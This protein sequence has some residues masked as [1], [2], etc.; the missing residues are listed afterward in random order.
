LCLRGCGISYANVGCAG[1]SRPVAPGRFDSIHSRSSCPSGAETTRPRPSAAS[2]F[3]SRGRWRWALRGLPGRR[4]WRE[5]KPDGRGERRGRLG[6]AALPTT[7]SG[8]ARATNCREYPALAARGYPSTMLRA[9]RANGVT[10][11]TSQ[12]RSRAHYRNGDNF[13]WT[14]LGRRGT[15]GAVCWIVDL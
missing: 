11:L 9:G 14:R 10:P 13:C 4:W 6:E 7:A 8:D 5:G 15:I 2:R 1:R 12:G 3:G